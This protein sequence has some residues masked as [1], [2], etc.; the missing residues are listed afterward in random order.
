MQILSHHQIN[1]EMMCLII[2]DGHIAFNVLMFSALDDGIMESSQ[3]PS[4]DAETRRLWPFPPACWY[5]RWLERYTLQVDRCKQ[6]LNTV[7]CIL[8]ICI[9]YI[10]ISMCIYYHVVCIDETL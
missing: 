1:N 8:C 9:I 3:I 6:G 5:K 2:S 7:L 4:C 10:Y